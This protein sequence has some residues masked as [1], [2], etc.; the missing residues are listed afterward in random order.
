MSQEKSGI[1]GSREELAPKQG[2]KRDLC[3][4]TLC[5]SAVL[6]VLWLT[7][8]GL[9]PSCGAHS[10]DERVQRILT[11]TPL[12]DGHDDFPIYVREIYQNHINDEEFTKAFVEGGLRGHVDIPRLKQ[13]RVGGSFWSV[14][15]PCPKDGSDF[16]D[17]NYAA[18]VR[19]TMEQVDVM[20]RVQKAY[21]NVFS[22]PP[23]GT[24]AMSA[25]RD[26][27]IISPLGIEGLH[28]IGNSLAHLRIFYELGVSYA[29]LTHNCHNRYAD[30]AVLEVPGGVKKAEPLWHG[31]SEE[32]ERL[33][34]EMNRLGMIVDLAHVSADTMR[35][36]LGAGK[37]EWTGSRAPVIYSHSSAYAICPHPRNVPDDI[38]EL[39]REK[40]SLV[41]VNFSPDFISCIASD[42]ADEMPTLDPTHATLSR[43]ADHIMHIGNLIGFEHVGIGSD[44]DGIP[45]VPQGL[46]DVSRFP[47]LI[48]E[49][50]KRGLT[51]SQASKV[52]GGNL[53]RVW[54]AVDEVALEMQAEGAL[55]AED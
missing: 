32:G 2:S 24:T 5:I 16:S 10:I 29:T 55:P 38:L 19:E 26:G 41:M 33:V 22:T 40:N 47:A 25:F 30:A 49:L 12:I 21:P 43:V 53:L 17:E 51:D 46:E 18:S 48:A 52:A 7:E 35:D 54:K 27:K 42:N 23:N 39:V 3:I 8:P 36:V 44:F 28:S 34:Y 9:K 4:W 15:V 14:F 45:T 11:H 13:G 20:S 37:S 50:L 6:A 1:L 31:V